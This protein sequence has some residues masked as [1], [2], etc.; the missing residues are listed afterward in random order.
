VSGHH[1]SSTVVQGP[2]QGIRIVDLTSTL[3][4]PYATQ[5]LSDLGADVIKVEAPEGDIRRQLGA[6]RHEG[7]TSQYLT[8]NRGK[9][10]IVLD[11]KRPEARDVVLKLCAQADVFVH[12]SRRE[13]MARLKLG[14]E[15][16]RAANPRIV[17]CAA[18]G[19][20]AD[21]PYAANPAYDDLIQG[22]VGLPGLQA[23]AG[24]IASYVPMNLGDRVCALALANVITSAL[25]WRERSGEGQAVELPMFETMTEFVLSEHMWGHVFVP[26]AEG[27]GA[28]RLFDR[29]PARTKDGYVCHWIATDA[30]YARFVA[31]LGHPEMC[32][33]P[34][35]ARRAQRY[36]NLPAF[37]AFVDEEL[38]KRTT[39]DCIALLQAADIP[40]MPMH[41]LESLV[42]D[43]HLQARGFFRTVHH[44]T[45]GE[46][47]SMAVPS[48]WSR[49]VPRN[50]RPAG[51]AGE[52]TREVLAEAGYA[53]DEIEQLIGSG[54]ARAVSQPGEGG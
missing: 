3:L 36:R 28:V 26:P 43:P 30:Q 7:M 29:R 12:N 40:A 19:F 52:N 11:L 24:G 50:D 18:V 23:R 8:V 38:G 41:T 48:Q 47:V 10:N 1:S 51:R 49:S 6:K 9:R 54:A 53:A 37:Q 44:P 45:E 14:Y 27:M 35:F 46:I 21:G 20:G 32:D 5:M 42:Q 39:A 15:D 34:R 17:Y 4:G 2:L 33:D 25:L 16:V 22:L 31:A 13:A